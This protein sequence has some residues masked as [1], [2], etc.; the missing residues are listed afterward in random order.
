MENILTFLKIINPRLIEEVE[1]VN[2][3]YCYIA[4]AI[5]QAAIPKRS[6]YAVA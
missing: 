6:V 4:Q 1:E 3:L 2:L 5:M